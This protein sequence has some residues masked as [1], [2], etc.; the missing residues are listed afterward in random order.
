MGYSPR[1]ASIA[2]GGSILK[3][4]LIVFAGASKCGK[5]TLAKRLAGE[6]HLPL[7]TFSATVRRRAS[8]RYPSSTHDV[9]QLQDVGAEL[10]KDNPGGFCREVLAQQKLKHYGCSVVDGLRH[11]SLLPVLRALNPDLNLVVIYAEASQ[12]TRCTRFT[13]VLTHAQLQEIDDHPVESQLQE[14]R[15]SADLILSTDRPEDDT[16]DEMCTW[17][18]RRKLCRQKEP[19]PEINIR[20][21]FL[22]LWT[23]FS[24]VWILFASFS[25]VSLS[26]SGVKSARQGLDPSDQ[27][28]PFDC[29]DA[30]G[31]AGTDFVQFHGQCWL[32]EADLR[33]LHPEV[34]P[35][36]HPGLVAK[37]AAI[38]RWVRVILIV[39]VILLLSGYSGY[40]VLQGFR[41]SRNWSRR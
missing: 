37:G 16:F 17:L 19:L 8:E 29:K 28:I 23:V 35:Q 14:L 34:P 13:P 12:A 2:S 4:T 26:Q 20:R 3:G 39:P 38:W 18:D 32:R 40:W 5:T 22:R 27:L 6:R 36:S 33:K 25:I 30:K 31:V 1:E 7:V 15:A 11:R 24:V 21:G 9:K 10:V 41:E